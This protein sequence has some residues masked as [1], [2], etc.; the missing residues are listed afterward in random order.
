MEDW[1]IWIMKFKIKRILR[2]A[3]SE[4]AARDVINRLEII[5]VI[6]NFYGYKK[7]YRKC[8]FNYGGHW[9]HAQARKDR[10]KLFFRHIFRPALRQTESSPYFGSA[11]EAEF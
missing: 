9:L 7:W 3:D 2:R 4:F 8:D 10:L 6:Y 5:C 1:K 11:A